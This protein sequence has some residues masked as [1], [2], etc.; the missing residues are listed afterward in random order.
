[1]CRHRRRKLR[2][3]QVTSASRIKGPAKSNFPKFFDIF[4]PVLL[5]INVSPHRLFSYDETGLIV[6]QH[7][8][9]KVISLKVK[10]RVSLSS[11]ERVHTWQLSLAW[12]SRLRMFLFYRCFLGATWRLNW[13]VLHQVQY[14]LVIGLDGTRKRDLS[15]GSNIFPFFEAV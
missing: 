13:T 3:H 15:K 7:K 5:L 8:L 1:M 12:M 14:Q 10:R 4:E 2:K 9:R 11:A 6:V